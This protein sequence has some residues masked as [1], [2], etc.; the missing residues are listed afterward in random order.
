MPDFRRGAAEVEKAQ[1][2]K[3]GGN[4]APF[5]PT[6]FWKAGD[7]SANERYWLILTSIEDMPRIDSIGMIPLEHSNKDGS[8]TWTS[9]E[10]VIARTDAALGESVDPL[11]KEFDARIVDSNMVVAVELEPEMKEVRGRQRPAGF[12]VKTLEIERRIRNDA[13]EL[14]EDT[15]TVTVPSWG[16]MT[17]AVGNFGAALVSY[18]QTESIL[19]ETP[20]KIVRVGGDKNTTYNVHGYP[21]LAEKMDLSGLT[22]NLEGIAYLGDNADQVDIDED[23][24]V[25]AHSLGSIL[26]DMRLNELAD[27]ERYNRIL[28][29]VREKGET[30]NKFAGGGKSQRNG[31][32][33]KERS[34]QRSESKEK[35]RDPEAKEALNRLK[36]RAKQRPAA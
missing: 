5:A 21:E 3:G 15:E 10:Q 12:K 20:V 32:A 2:K 4:Y 13:G 11:N 29:A 30:L 14:T 7:E 16:F 36:D 24:L 6:I 33:P 27:E 25:T 1:Q 31:S 18:D 28:E 23:P 22:D 34:S 19:N 8:K 35:Q 26:L 17:Q 9:F